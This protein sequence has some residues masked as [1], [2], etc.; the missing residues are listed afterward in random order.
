MYVHSIQFGSIDAFSDYI[1]TNFCFQIDPDRHDDD[2]DS[3]E[4][5]EIMEDIQEALLM[6]RRQGVLP[7]V[8]IARILAGEASGQFSTDYGGATDANKGSIPLS[9]ALDYVG[10]ILEESHK[11][12]SRLTTEVEEYNAICNSME[13]EIESLFRVSNPRASPNTD[14][15]EYESSRMNIDDLYYRVRAEENDTTKQNTYKPIEAFWREMNQSE[16][17]FDVIARFFAKGIII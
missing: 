16:D 13:K 9:V 5:N 1:F 2:S 12:I 17:S 11:E 6:A 10:S 15:G 3:D 7:P 8:R 14:K 4:L